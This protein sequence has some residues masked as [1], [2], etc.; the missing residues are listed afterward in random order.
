ML[1]LSYKFHDWVDIPTCS[2]YSYVKP[3]PSRS[4]TGSQLYTPKYASVSQ[5]SSAMLNYG[6]RPDG[7]GNTLSFGSPTDVF[8]AGWNGPGEEK[9]DLV[10]GQIFFSDGVT[11]THMTKKFVQIEYDSLTLDE[12]APW[13][14][15]Y[16]Y[17]VRGYDDLL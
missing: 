12:T 3:L 6:I 4:R 8:T 7:L 9:V 15:T 13:I 14:K 10:G 5:Y 2:T 1:A 16:E 11:Q 17:R